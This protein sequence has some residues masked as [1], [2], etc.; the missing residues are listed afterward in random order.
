MSFIIRNCRI[1]DAEAL[2]KLNRE[3]LG[4]DYPVE[5]LRERLETVLGS[6]K[7]RIW[8]AVMG[9]QVVGYIHACGYDVIYAPHMKDIMGIAVSS[10]CRRVGIGRALLYAV[11]EWGRE[12][13]AAGIRLVSGTDRTDAH[14]FYRSCGYNGGKT[15]LN[16]KKYL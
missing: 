16:L 14:A 12:D 3:D 2:Q 13:G 4:Y 15:Q 5:E 8:V 9:Q 1:E 6:E 7:D 11:E 10:A